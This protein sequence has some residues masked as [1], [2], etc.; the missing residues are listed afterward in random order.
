MSARLIQLLSRY[1][2]MALVAAAT[3][4]VGEPTPEQA[5][6]INLSASGVA[7]GIGGFIFLLVDA[8][9]HRAETGGFLKGAGQAKG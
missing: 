4:I 9:I 6:A 1:I 5:E 3:A 7:A 2:G 8:L